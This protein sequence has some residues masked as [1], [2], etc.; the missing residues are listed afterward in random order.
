[1]KIQFLE[2]QKNLAEKQ[3]KNL[4][5][6]LALIEELNEK[7]DAKKVATDKA[8]VD[9][10]ATLNEADEKAYISLQ[11]E[12]TNLESELEE[13]EKGKALLENFVLPY[14]EGKLVREVEEYIEKTGFVKKVDNYVAIYNK[15]LE[16][17]E[18]LNRQYAELQVSCQKLKGEVYDIAREVRYI[19]DAESEIRTIKDRYEDQQRKIDYRIETIEV[20]KIKGEC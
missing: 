18:A 9:Y 4:A 2:V 13:A 17:A 16:D 6:K 5:E 1:M 14:P 20:K 15:L 10:Y 12:L 7:I 8:Q 19:A 3:Q 11:N